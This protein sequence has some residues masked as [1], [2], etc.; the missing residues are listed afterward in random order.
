MSWWTRVSTPVS[1]LCL[2]RVSFNPTPS[3]I[4]TGLP[5]KRVQA[6]KEVSSKGN[7]CLE[8]APRGGVLVVLCC[9]G[10]HQFVT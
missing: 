3:F 5:T 4:G 6:W 10:F 1:T 8:D 9:L 2:P 7:R